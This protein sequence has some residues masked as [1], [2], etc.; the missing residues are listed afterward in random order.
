MNGTSA[1]RILPFPFHCV[2]LNIVNVKSIDKDMI[3]N[4]FCRSYLCFNSELSRI[5]THMVIQ[6]LPSMVDG[7]Q[8]SNPVFSWQNTAYMA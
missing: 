8:L 7:T 3:R 4:D 5:C 1:V 6:L 2:S